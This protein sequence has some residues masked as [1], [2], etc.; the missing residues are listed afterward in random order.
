[1]TDHA[2][3]PDLFGCAD[4]IVPACQRSRITN[5]PARRHRG[6]TADGRRVRDL[7]LS[8]MSALGNPQN[9]NLQA[10]CLKAAR[11]VVAAE[12]AGARIIEASGDLN[13]M[14]RIENAADRAVRRLGLPAQVK[15][16]QHVPLR[17]RLKTRA[18]VPAEAA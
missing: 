12:I 15:D 17:E 14:V 13:E 5:D 9:A 6:T 7:F 10:N 3:L 11:L 4:V 1:M 16:A 8:F 18:G 2:L